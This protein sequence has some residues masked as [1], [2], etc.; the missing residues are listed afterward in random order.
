MAKI[1]TAHVEI[2][3]VLNDEALE[4]MAA[5]I[6]AAVRAGVEAGMKAAAPSPT[7]I[8]VTYG[9]T[10]AATCTPHLHTEHVAGCFRCE[11]NRDE[12]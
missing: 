7:P 9:G 5:R 1:G 8:T 4:Q 2:K 11:L 10:S 6:E 3:P 12:R